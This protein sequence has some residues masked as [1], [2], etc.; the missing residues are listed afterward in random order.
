MKPTASLGD[1]PQTGHQ[2]SH[3][4]LEYHHFIRYASLDTDYASIR[5]V[6]LRKERAA[7]LE[8]DVFLEATLL[9]NGIDITLILDFLVDADFSL[10][11]E[12]T[13]CFRLLR[14][15]EEKVRV[16]SF[17]FGGCDLTVGI[18]NG[19]SAWIL[20]A[21]ASLKISKRFPPSCP[22]PS[23][24]EPRLAPS[25][26]RDASQALSRREA[27]QDGAACCQHGPTAGAAA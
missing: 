11:E 13:C 20:A 2:Y 19:S 7:S 6:S 16:V 17:F 25:R 1:Q 10:F 18:S 3:N 4:T 27:A 8:L 23:S 22:K 9:K 5:Y 26:R 21:E 14:S 15:G 12:A 24:P